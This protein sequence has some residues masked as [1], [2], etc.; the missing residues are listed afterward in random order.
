MSD[1]SA[2]RAA[3]R[4]PKL[5]REPFSGFALMALLRRV[6]L[7][8]LGPVASAR[9]SRNGLS[10]HRCETPI[11]AVI[12]APLYGSGVNSLGLL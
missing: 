9:A 11:L 6:Q 8:R 5:S 3:G 2:I 10:L 12:G 1:C 7:S 4:F